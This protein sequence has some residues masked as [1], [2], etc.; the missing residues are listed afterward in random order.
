MKPSGAEGLPRSSPEGAF[1]CSIRTP[2]W[3]IESSVY[4][5]PR[6]ARDSRREPPLLKIATTPELKQATTRVQKGGGRGKVSEGLGDATR[7]GP[8]PWGSPSS[9]GGICLLAGI[10]Y[11]GSTT[12][13]RDP[14]QHM[15]AWVA[16]NCSSPK[17]SSPSQRWW[18]VW[19]D[20]AEGPSLARSVWSSQAME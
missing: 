4:A 7:A 17:S 18:W 14:A 16:P 9:T 8:R 12:L 10:L 19:R 2:L 15:Q 20:W 6:P 11:F 1:G 5:F 3:T 13:A